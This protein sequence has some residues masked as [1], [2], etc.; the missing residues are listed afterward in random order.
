MASHPELRLWVSRFWWLPMRLRRPR[1]SEWFG[2]S[3]LI[4]SA[5]APEVH[6][7]GGNGDANGL[8]LL[9][10]YGRCRARLREF[11]ARVAPAQAI[12]PARAGMRSGD[13][14]SAPEFRR[15]R[16]VDAQPR[17]GAAAR[18][19]ARDPHA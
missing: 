15:D 8:A 4:I 12:E 3:W 18:G 5:L 2:V 10:T 16:Q 17:N 6:Y 7:I 14:Y 19:S 1:M 9:S 13:F 11:V